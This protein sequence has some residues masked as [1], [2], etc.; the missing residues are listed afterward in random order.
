MVESKDNVLDFIKKEGAVLPIQISR[1]LKIDTM[2]S[3]AMLSE[4][5]NHGKI[6]VTEHLRVG[7]SPI[8]YTDESKLENYTKYL[9]DQDIKTIAILKEKGIVNDK[10]ISPLQRVSY[11]IVKDLAKSIVLKKDDGDK[12]IFW[13]YFLVDE[14]AAK[15]KILEMMNGKESKKEPK[16]KQVSLKQPSLKQPLLE[17]DV[18]EK[19]KEESLLEKDVDEEKETVEEEK[20]KERKI[21]KRIENDSVKEFF[22]VN[23]ISIWEEK[24]IRK[25][26]EVNYIVSFDSI[27][28]KLKYFAKFRDKK[29]INEGDVSLAYN[30]AGKLPLLFLSKGEL[31]KNAKKLVDED[32][33][34]VVFKRIKE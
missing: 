15:E 26:K 33:K 13:R 22:R 12:E 9:N 20:P 8:Y 18:D 23:N 4:L 2:F 31:N 7:G 29:K 19:K 17:K 6:K 32:F 5:V 28:G 27:F 24:V 21:S 14:D 16:E 10:E 11:R 1:E 3:G 25:G 30:E 34:G